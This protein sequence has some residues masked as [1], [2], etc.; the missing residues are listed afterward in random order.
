M[1]RTAGI[2]QTGW[3]SAV[4]IPQRIGGP[5]SSDIDIGI[6]GVIPILSSSFTTALEV[7]KETTKVKLTH[8]NKAKA[9]F[10]PYRSTSVWAMRRCV[11]VTHLQRVWAKTFNPVCYDSDHH[12]QLML[13]L[14]I[15]LIL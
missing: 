12:D 8:H 13:Q 9:L 1:A 15:S 10:E 2:T 3:G 4:G 14:F 6:S 5:L 7:L 11:G